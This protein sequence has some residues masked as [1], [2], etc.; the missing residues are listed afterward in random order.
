[1]DAESETSSGLG[2]AGGRNVDADLAG[3]GT[4]V[5]R[6]RQELQLTQTQLGERIGWAQERISV[7]EGGRYGLPSLPAL[8]RLSH[9]LEVSLSSL[10]EAAG[11][12]ALPEP[13]EQAVAD[14]SRA[15]ALLY[16]LERLLAI[17]DT[18]LH[19]VMNQASDWLLQALDSDKIDIF[20]FDP[21]IDSLVAVGTSDSPMGRLQHE[22]GMGRLPLANGGRTVEAFTEGEAVVTGDAREENVEP[23]GITEGMGIRSMLQVPI[24]IQGQRRGV[25]SAVS[26]QVDKYTDEEVRFSMTLARWIALLIHR[27]ELLER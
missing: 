23:L 3:L 1:V 13:M 15:A 16:A 2:D 19:E 17:E 25:L 24:W 4:L 27:E 14:P 22:L 26:A 7:L 18:G 6:R 9:A 5:R 21:A 20:L 12:N 11:F 10:V 8:V